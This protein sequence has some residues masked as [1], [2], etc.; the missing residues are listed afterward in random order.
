MNT[1]V[2]LRIRGLVIQATPAIAELAVELIKHTCHEVETF[3]IETRLSD[4]VQTAS[5]VL[6]IVKEKFDFIV[7]PLTLP[8]FNSV[9]IA[10]YVHL[11]RIT[12]RLVL[13]SATNASRNTIL[14]LFDDFVAKLSADNLGDSVCRLLRESP[15]RALSGAAIQSAVIALIEDRHTFRHA[16][17]LQD[18]MSLGAP[19]EV[20]AGYEHSLECL[21][22]RQLET[23]SALARDVDKL[24]QIGMVKG[25]VFIQSTHSNDPPIKPEEVVNAVKL[26]TSALAED[27]EKGILALGM[28]SLPE[29]NN[30]LVDAL[31]NGYRDVREMA[32]IELG[33]HQDPRC[34][35]FLTTMAGDK[36]MSSTVIGLL[37][38]FG[39]ET[40]PIL[41]ALL[42]S[43]AFELAAQVLGRLRDHRAVPYLTQILFNKD[44]ITEIG[45]DG[46]ATSFFSISKYKRDIA[47]STLLVIG[48]PGAQEAAKA[49][50]SLSKEIFDPIRLPPGY[51]MADD[52]IPTKPLPILMER[53]HT[54]I[55]TFFNE[56]LT[57]IRDEL[58]NKLTA[59]RRNAA[60]GEEM[61]RLP[62]FLEETWEELKRNAKDQAIDISEIYDGL[63]EVVM[64]CD[65]SSLLW[66]DE[67][68][69]K[70]PKYWRLFREFASAIW[71]EH[72]KRNPEQSFPAQP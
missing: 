72:V 37:E 58:E 39:S 24:T 16:P 50:E 71:K 26:T 32:A 61:R 8:H 65:R 38:G 7:L 43:P 54:A 19:T 13:W 21:P 62:A 6:S 14:L 44:K 46:S 34:L 17:T 25:N 64:L 30:A 2:P 11:L 47:Y 15:R 4:S 70:S 23:Y 56:T 53:A 9:R 60:Q 10:E 20:S 69:P 31:N 45:R 1:Q 52:T 55:E 40:T 42:N 66:A 57:L 28:I 51:W 18:Y 35:P 12:T 63:G 5:D 68:R 67:Q 22:H 49:Y 33:K 41:C 29:A 59:K 48:T 27:R 3:N 36:D